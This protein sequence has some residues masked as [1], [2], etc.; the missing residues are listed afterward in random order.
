MQDTNLR[1][2]QLAELEILKVFKSI[3]EKEDFAYFL[4][5]GTAIG[6]VRHG[7]FIPW[8]DDI[9]VGLLRKDYERFL[10]KALKYLPDNMEIKHWKITDHY[11][12]YTMQLVNKNVEF[13]TKRLGG[14]V[15]Q[16]VWID[17]F[18]LDGVPK[19]GI[20]REVHY[21]I[22]KMYRVLLGLHNAKTERIVEARCRLKRLVYEIAKIIPV[23]RFIDPVQIKKKLDKELQKY[24]NA[25]SG[26]IGNL[27]GAYHEKE[28][29]ESS[30]F[31]NEDSPKGK[32]VT[33]ENESFYAPLNIKKYLEIQ[34]GDYMRLP[35]TDKQIPKHNILDIC[36]VGDKPQEK[37]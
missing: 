17:I 13:E 7:G 1:K 12:D 21:V 5:G 16:N 20:R 33:F 6:A 2:A 3:C 35:P 10:D 23:G 25:G 8:D 4:L 36:F 29:F 24:N 37:I 11:K 34:Y 19:P 31:I 14:T 26:F 22:L 27:M 9:D 32:L 28:V 15:R 18:P 30:I